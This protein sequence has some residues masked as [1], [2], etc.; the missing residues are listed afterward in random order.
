MSFNDK[1]KE[2]GFV[3]PKGFMAFDSVGDAVKL[4]KEK[5]AR[6]LADS[7]SIGVLVLAQLAVIGS[8]IALQPR[9]VRAGAVYHDA[10]D[11]DLASCFVA[12]VLRKDELLQIHI[13]CPPWCPFSP[14]A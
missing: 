4:N 9:I 5:T 12:G 2:L 3:S 7:N 8:D 6:M 13:I 1:A 14:A 10:L 11:G